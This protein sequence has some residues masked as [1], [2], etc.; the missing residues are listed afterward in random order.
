MTRPPP[1]WPPG[2]DWPGPGPPW[3]AAPRRFRRRFLLVTLGVLV[4][5]VGVG[6]VIGMNAKGGDRRPPPAER[7]GGPFGAVWFLGFVLVVGGGATALAYRRISRPV[8]DLLGAADKV[9]RGDYDVDVRPDGPRELRALTTTFGTMAARL[10]RAEDQRRRFLAEVTHE[11]RTPLAVL[12]GRIEAQLDGIHPRDDRHLA[13]LLEET[14][15]LGRLVDDLHTL[16]L[17][18]AGRLTLHHEPVSPRALVE[19]TVA[20]QAALAARRG[21]TVTGQVDGDVPEIEADPTRLRQVLANLSSNALRHSP[22]GGQVHVRVDAA[23]DGVRFTVADEGPGFPP[24]RL[25]HLFERFTPAG[26]SRGSGLGLSIARDLV[27]AHGGSIRAENAPGGG[28]VVTFEV[29]V[30]RQA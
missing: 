6:V 17:A 11:L 3:M 12:Q 26:D 13:S 25:E 23:G 22:E 30:A 10:A 2:E 5:L 14:Q 24:E 27:A 8:A 4:S 9:S 18:D 21:I 19:D 15:I 7:R 29:P 28:A 16:A 1:W 20:G